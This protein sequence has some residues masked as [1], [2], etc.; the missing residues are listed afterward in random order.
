MSSP[1]SSTAWKHWYTIIGTAVP[2][3][4]YRSSSDT[5]NTGWRGGKFDWKPGGGI[6]LPLGAAKGDFSGGAGGPEVTGY[7]G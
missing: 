6:G 5:P 2:S 7:G 3:L 1:N 4:A